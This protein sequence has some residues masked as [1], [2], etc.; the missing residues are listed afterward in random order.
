[1]PVMESIIEAALEHAEANVDAEQADSDGNPFGPPR[2]AIVGCGAPGTARVERG[3]AAHGMLAG[4]AR[5]CET[6]TVAVGPNRQS[7]DTKLI[8]WSLVCQSAAEPTSREEPSS[9]DA[10]WRR[11]RERTRDVEL[12]VVTGNL[13]TPDAARR[14]SRVVDVVAEGD[15]PTV[16]VPTIP[17]RPVQPWAERALRTFRGTADTLAP[18]DTAEPSANAQRTD[19]PRR[20]DG[21]IEQVLRAL[22]GSVTGSMAFPADVGSV[23][24]LLENGVVAVPVVATIERD[25][26]PGDWVPDRESV[27]ASLQPCY[28][29]SVLDVGSGRP[30]GWLAYLVGGAELTLHEA[31]RLEAMFPKLL[32]GDELD[33][34]V[35]GHIDKET[36]GVTQLT[37]LVFL[38]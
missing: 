26:D 27:D 37:A 15:A 23:Y 2:A 33:G 31:Q 14:L 8:D 28:D 38:D 6:T 25:A 5:R 16:V 10:D 34:V 29:G 22:L 30:R 12:S 35:C 13:D 18:V 19:E 32:T 9:A 7:L 36:S 3:V 11:L 20:V 17:D 4:A 24:E 1:M 21:P